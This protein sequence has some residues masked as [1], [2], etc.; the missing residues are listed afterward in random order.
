VASI[1]NRDGRWRALV[2]KNGLSKCDTFS[3]RA[4]ADFGAILVVS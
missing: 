1:I 4:A 3:T 2:R